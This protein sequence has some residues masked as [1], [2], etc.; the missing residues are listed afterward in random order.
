M[1]AGNMLPA[2]YKVKDLLLSVDRP[3]FTHLETSL[4]WLSLKLK[5]LQMEH[6]C[7]Q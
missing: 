7:W 1:K 5:L 2:L 4:V 6:N 3:A